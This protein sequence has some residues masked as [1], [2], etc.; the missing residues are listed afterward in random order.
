MPSHTFPASVLALSV[1]VAN[2]PPRS[3]KQNILS[4]YS[5]LSTDQHDSLSEC[6]AFLPHWRRLLFNLGFFYAT[7][8]ERKRFGAIGYNSN[9]D[10]TVPD[11]TISH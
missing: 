1:K 9:Y 10:F 11:L 5:L 3:V 6:P 4:A 8:L 7:L 2:E